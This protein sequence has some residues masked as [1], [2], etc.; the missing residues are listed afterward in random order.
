MSYRQNKFCQYFDTLLL[1]L[2]LVH[3]L[4]ETE[5]IRVLLYPQQL[6]I[7]FKLAV[8]QFS[9]EVYSAIFE[10]LAWSILIGRNLEYTKHCKTQRPS[11][12]LHFTRGQ[13]QLLTINNSPQNCGSFLTGGGEGVG[14]ARRPS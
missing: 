8:P 1:N 11:E 3:A 14:S 7:L 9:K 5:C 10:V 13:L 12:R 4:A 2:R 6:A